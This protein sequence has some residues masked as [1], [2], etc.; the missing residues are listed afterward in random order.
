MSPE[1]SPII[2]LLIG[3]LSSQRC[4]FHACFVRVLFICGG[5]VLLEVFNL[6]GFLTNASYQSRRIL[7]FLKDCIM[8]C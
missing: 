1:P 6:L 7:F 5:C 4:L 8:E 2:S 3:L